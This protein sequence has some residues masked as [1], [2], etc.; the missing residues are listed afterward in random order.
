[1]SS[2]VRGGFWR[3]DCCLCSLH[4]KKPRLI[5][6]LISRAELSDLPQ[7]IMWPCRNTNSTFGL[8]Q[9][10]GDQ[11]DFFIRYQNLPVF[12]MPPSGAPLAFVQGA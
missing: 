11:I 5:R 3:A 10:A 6:R 12:T 8:H 4:D 7:G 9:Q 1:M 2:D